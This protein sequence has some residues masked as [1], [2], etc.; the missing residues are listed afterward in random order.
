M[1][2]SQQLCTQFVLPCALLWY[3]TG[4]FNPYPSGHWAFVI[5]IKYSCG[6]LI[7][8]MG[9]P[10]PWNVGFISKQ[11][12]IRVSV[13][14]CP[15][16]AYANSHF[17]EKTVSQP[18]CLWWQSLYQE[19]WSLYWTWPGHVLSICQLLPHCS[20]CNVTICSWKRQVSVP[21]RLGNGTGDLAVLGEQPLYWP[22]TGTSW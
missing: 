22:V 14:R 2:T 11:T 16:Y 4:K 18:S 15:F 9:I 8:I 21:E 6:S 13:S 12:Q 20:S 19:R 7:C 17:K 3:G 5:K 10:V 1:S